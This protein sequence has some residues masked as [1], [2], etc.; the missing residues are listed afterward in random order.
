MSDRIATASKPEVGQ[1][2]ARLSIL[3]QTGLL[4]TP[5][6]PEFDRV[7]QLAARL[8]RAPIAAVTLVDE[9]RQFFKSLVG[10]HEPRASQR[11]T[12]RSEA[13]CRRVTT[14]GKPFVVNDVR[15]DPLLRDDS[16]VRVM[17]IVA[18]LGVPLVTRQGYALGSLCVVDRVPRNWCGDD[19]DTLVDLAAMVMTEIE[20]R[21]ECTRHSQSVRELRLLTS[22]IEAANDSVVICEA[23][24]IDDIGPKIVYVNKAFSRTTGYAPEEILGKTP[25]MLHGPKTDRA[26]LNTIRA[27]LAAREP[28]HA[29]VVNYR[30]D[31]AEYWVELSIRPIPD[32]DGRCTHFVSIQRDV[33]GRK[34]A[35]DRL[36]ASERKFRAMLDGSFQFVGLLDPDGTLIEANRT[37]LEFAGVERHEVVGLPLAKTPWFS[38]TEEAQ[39]KVNAA[40]D[41][42]KRGRFVRYEAE[43]TGADG[44]VTVIDFSISPV[45]DESGEVVLLV[46]EGRDITERKQAEERTREL[47][48]RLTEA[49]RRKDEFLAMLAHELRNPLA[50]IA[51]AVKVLELRDGEPML[52][53]R[54]RDLIGR[55]VRSL[56]Q[57]V[58]DLLDVSRITRG[59]IQLRLEPV[60]LDEAVARALATTRPLLRRRRHEVS[61]SLPDA[62]VRLFADPLR[63]EQLLVNLVT[64]AAKY[65]DPGGLI[66]VS[67]TI[68]ESTSEVILRISDNGVGIAP[69]LL[70][71]VFDPFTQADTTL[72]RSE[73]GLGIGLTLVR[74]LVQLHGGTVEATSPGPDQ[75]STFVIRLPLAESPVEP[76]AEPDPSPETAEQA[77]DALRVLVV[78][79]NLM[80][81]ES[82]A[83][84][85]GHWG[86]TVRVCH[87]GRSAVSAAKEFRPE[88][89]LLDIGLP[90]M[91]GYAV[92]RALRAR[93]EHLGTVLIAVTG[94]GRDTK[95]EAAENAE[96]DHHFVKPVNLNSLERLL[97]S[98]APAIP[99]LGRESEFRR[100]MVRK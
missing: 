69:E 62:H 47:A 26:T 39:V 78:D 57:L 77:G 22:A 35:D 23:G 52:R 59:K 58:D 64:N 3:H 68:D 79:D 60:N 81:A 1:G 24:L 61:V 40:I 100:E 80:A 65:T 97:I 94:Y 11:E 46:P 13:L 88:V 2:N 93:P 31:G 32:E 83:V 28:V 86:H 44:R 99:E 25:R 7:T 82:L 75:G 29:E 67:G 18:Y 66:Q 45:K 42:A 33:T 12:P 41:E 49:D 85:L 96:F 34:E 36:L 72:D 17:G 53:A 8:L 71:H 21:T 10:V 73:G 55:Q 56:S 48:E 38:R 91:D 20:L 76:E 37:A 15:T 74:S 50:P 16:A 19:L 30:K 98:M 87:D 54:M 70:P 95:R 90:G 63:L 9:N 5:S 43:H 89:V 27:H 14:T 4:D 84:I 92:A 6:E 51:N